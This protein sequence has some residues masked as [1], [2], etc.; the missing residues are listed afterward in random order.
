MGL[1]RRVSRPRLRL[2][3]ALLAALAV[4]AAP[5]TALSASDRGLELVTP[6]TPGPTVTYVEQISAQ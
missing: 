3:V 5:A 2:R 1:K 4:A 6:E